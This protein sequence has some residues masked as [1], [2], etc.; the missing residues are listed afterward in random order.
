VTYGLHLLLFFWSEIEA[1]GRLS[2]LDYGVNNSNQIL[3]LMVHSKND[4]IHFVKL[5]LEPG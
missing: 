1:I 5:A 4:N 2:H 3:E